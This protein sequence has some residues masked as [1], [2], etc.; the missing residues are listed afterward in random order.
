[1][2]NRLGREGEVMEYNVKVAP[3]TRI[4]RIIRRFSQRNCWRQTPN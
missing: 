1:M 2:G 3:D 4:Q